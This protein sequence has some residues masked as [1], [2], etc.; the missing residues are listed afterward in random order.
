MLVLCNARRNGGFTLIE[1][2]V[3]LT[4]AGVVLALGIPAFGAWLQDTQVRTVSESILDAMT[5]AK[6]AALNNPNAVAEFALNTDTSWKITLRPT[7]GAE[8]TVAE[9]AM[10]EGSS[11]SV[12]ATLT[13]AAASGTVTF[14]SLG[15]VIDA[16]PLTQVDV[17]SVAGTKKLR[18]RVD[19]GGVIKMCDPDPGIS[20]SD[21][22]YCI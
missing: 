3:T 21:P 13:P 6:N 4:I 22:R 1:L 18:I 2:M 17:E 5:Q 10:H 7:G 20:S 12:T 11:A 8:V 14:D 15:R 19:R 16:G 9:R